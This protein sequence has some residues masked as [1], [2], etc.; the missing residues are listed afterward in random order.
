M[1]ARPYQRDA[2]LAVAREFRVN[3]VESTIVVHATGTGKT[4]VMALIGEMYRRMSGGRVLVLA[5][6]EELIDQARRTLLRVLPGLREIDVGIEA[7]SSRAPSG[8]PYVIASPQ[9][10]HEDR[11]ASFGRRDFGLIIVDEAHLSAVPSWMRIFDHF[12][13]ARRAG[14]TATP[15]RLDGRPLVPTLYNTVAHVYELPDAIRDGYLSPL[16]FRR[17]TTATYDAAAVARFDL[18]A[19]SGQV[20]PEIERE[21]MRTEVLART[22]AAVLQL[23]GKTLVFCVSV[24]HAQAL[25]E[26]LGDDAA[27]MDGTAAKG[28]RRRVM[29]R[30][31]TGG[32]RILCNCVLYTLGLDIPDLANVVLAR[33]TASRALYSQ[34]V[35]RVTRLFPGKEHGLVLDTVG[36]V[37]VHGLVTPSAAFSGDDEGGVVDYV[38]DGEAAPQT[39]ADEEERALLESIELDLSRAPSV[40]VSEIDPELGMF[41]ISVEERIFG[42]RNATAAQVAGLRKWGV[43]RP[44]LLSFSQAQT[45]FEQVIARAAE[46]LCTLKQGRILAKRG[47]NP[48]ASRED[49]DWGIDLIAAAGWRRTPPV[50]LARRGLRYSGSSPLTMKDGLARARGNS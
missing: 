10:L 39:R 26:A 11:L 19:D 13:C 32:L 49:A 38:T 25:A 2:A 6:R 8:T 1:R 20:D 35:G 31:R 9:S 36:I 17:V 46:G 7:G 37:G 47:L 33:V 18:M 34:M 43:E 12:S 44:E 15:D 42:E 45:V 4:F 22:A 21:A 3:G 16:R 30:F 50:V 40:E 24:R 41:G 29:D 5:P 14:M 27:A 48:N 28:E 23:E